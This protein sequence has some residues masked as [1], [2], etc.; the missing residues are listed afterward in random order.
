MSRGLKNA[1]HTLIDLPAEQYEQLGATACAV[2]VARGLPIALLQVCF[3]DLFVGE[4]EE[5]KL[6][7]ILHFV[8]SL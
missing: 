4:E 2:S 5:R 6:L 3:L 7:I 8:F 1:R